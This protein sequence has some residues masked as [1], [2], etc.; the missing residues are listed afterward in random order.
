MEDTMD[1]GEGEIVRERDMDREWRRGR[2]VLT[3]ARVWQW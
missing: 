3:S 2:E 1:L